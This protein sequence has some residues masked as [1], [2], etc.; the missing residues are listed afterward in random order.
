MTSLG[1][2]R[3]PTFIAEFSFYCSYNDEQTL[4][5]LDD[6]RLF[7][8][9]LLHSCYTLKVNYS[10]NIFGTFLYF[11]DI[12]KNKDKYVPF[13]IERSERLKRLILSTHHNSYSRKLLF[14]CYYFQTNIDKSKEFGVDI[15]PHISWY[16]K[17]SNTFPEEIISIIHDFNY[18]HQNHVL[19]ILEITNKK[20]VKDY[21][22]KWNRNK[23]VY[24]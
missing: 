2:K 3:L 19:N 22:V 5:I 1:K 21:I 9:L 15:P 18:D 24:D 6:D 13:A 10:K 17:L 23:A 8:S 14:V 11:I 7:Y 16:S 20:S 12:L 4:L